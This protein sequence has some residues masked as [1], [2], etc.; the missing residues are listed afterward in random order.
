MLPALNAGDL[1]PTTATHVQE[2][3]MFRIGDAQLY[4]TQATLLI[5]LT[6]YAKR[7]GTTTNTRAL[8]EHTTSLNTATQ[9]LTAYHAKE[10]AHAKH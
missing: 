2:D 8:R 3:S 1:P 9:L 5:L 10:E 6:L 7:Q 4:A